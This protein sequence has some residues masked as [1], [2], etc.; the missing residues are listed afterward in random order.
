MTVGSALLRNAA[1]VV[2]V[3]GLLLSGLGAVLDPAAF[4]PGWLAATFF[5]LALSLGAMVTL[6][7]WHLTGG[8]WGEALAPALRAMLAALPVGLVALA[9][10]LVFGLHDLF[11][12][13]GPPETLPEVVRNKAIW[14]NIPFFIARTAV[15]VAAW[16]LIAWHLDAWR[17]ATVRHRGLG[18]GGPIAWVFSVTFFAFDWLMSL[19]PAWYSD[20]FGL[21]VSSGIVTAGLAGALMLTALGRPSPDETL[22]GRLQDVGNLLLAV[23]VGW[24][25]LAFSQYIVIWMGN[26]PHEI[27]WYI[28][29]GTGGWR[30]VSVALLA[31]FA[32]L[33]IAALMSRRVKRSRR[34]LIS[35]SASVLVGHALTSI[36]LVLPSFYAQGFSISW[37]V[38]AA[39]AGLGGI[40]LAVLMRRLQDVQEEPAPTTGRPEGHP[41]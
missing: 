14:L 37:H 32:F 9:V 15:Y 5:W 22:T 31:F 26:L 1:L 30:V 33:P 3:V 12:W 19:E 11:P 13:T 27:G 36:W 8:G 38:F 17:A 29:R 18:A 35:V 10:P 41:A 6:L 7:T 39:F 34:A 16:L 2:G 25:F 23:V 4:H 40:W 28:H 20:I 24:V 21:V